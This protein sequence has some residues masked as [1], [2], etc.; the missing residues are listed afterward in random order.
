MINVTYPRIDHRRGLALQVQHYRGEKSAPPSPRNLDDVSTVTDAVNHLAHIPNRAARLAAAYRIF[1]RHGEIA[2]GCNAQNP[3]PAELYALC[4]ELCAKVIR[5]CWPGC[6]AHEFHR[7]KLRARRVLD[8]GGTTQARPYDK[9]VSA[10]ASHQPRL[11]PFQLLLVASAMFN[12]NAAQANPIFPPS[13][14]VGSQ[15]E[16]VRAGVDELRV[17]GV[18]GEIGRAH[19]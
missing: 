9:A 17:G 8:G 4:L 10:R 1:G 2:A 6:T 11:G 3:R 7:A 12:L 18:L 19:V 15:S 14:F 5:E 16:A 13:L